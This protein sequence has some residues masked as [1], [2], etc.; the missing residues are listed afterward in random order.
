MNIFSTFQRKCPLNLIV[1]KI[2]SIVAIKISLSSVMFKHMQAVLVLLAMQ[3][4]Y[5]PTL[6]III[7]EY[8]KSMFARVISVNHTL[9]NEN[10]IN[11]IYESKYSRM[12]QVKFVEDSLVED[13][14]KFFKG[15]L[16]QILLGPFLN[17]LSHI[18]LH[19]NKF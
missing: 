10:I 17:T 5:V 1:D 4:Y 11:L 16:P 15:C 13:P 7:Y 19:K 12:D 2:S 18:T 3:C 8:I 9:G 6:K 14:F